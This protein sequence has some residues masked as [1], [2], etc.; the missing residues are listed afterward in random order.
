MYTYVYIYTYVNTD[1]YSQQIGHFSKTETCV[2]YP[3]LP[4]AWLLNGFI[5]VP[6][7]SEK[8]EDVYI[9]IYIYVY[10]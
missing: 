6:S 3:N 5:I 4:K 8:G 7:L 2:L 10:I 9:Y 1:G